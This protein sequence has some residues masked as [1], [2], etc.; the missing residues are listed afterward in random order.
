MT[1]TLE[2]TDI[3]GISHDHGDDIVHLV[4]NI[5]ANE[6]NRALCGVIPERAIPAMETPIDSVCPDCKREA[7]KLG[8]WSSIGLT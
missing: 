4:P 5:P 3:D 1:E 7:I 8:V 6:R 2:T